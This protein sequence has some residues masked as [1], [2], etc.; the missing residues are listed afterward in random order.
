MKVI[1]VVGA[2][3]NFMKVA[4]LHRAIQQLSGWTSKIVH[5]GQHF[6]AKMSD[7]FFTQLELP[8]PDYFLGIGGGSHTEVTA[9][10]MLAFEK[11]V[12]DEKPD[13]II[14]VGDVTSTLACTLV[15]IKMGIHVAHVEAGLRSF[16]R[17]MPEELNR[18]L[19]DSVANYLFVTEESGLNHL[20]NEGV[21]DEKV[22][23]SGNVM[24]DSLV[25]YQE[26]AKNSTILTDLGLRPSDSGQSSSE[27]GLI[28]SNYIVMTMH[29]PAN[30]DTEKGL[31]SILELMELSAQ[32]TKIVFPIHPRTRAHMD[33]FGLT[34]RMEALPNL[35][36]TEP[37]GYLEFI[38]LMSHA[39]AILTDS[40]GIQEETTYLGIP[41]L[42]FRD[43]TERP[44]TV[45]LGTNQLLADLD[46][47]KTYQALE[48]I[49]AG[50]VKK[51]SI[52][53]LW[54]GHAAERIANTLHGIFEKK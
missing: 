15:A 9:H 12:A 22:F 50:E 2:R 43:S 54:D 11:I 44:V 24:I 33:K 4:P 26:K 36:L 46:P 53:P 1:Q 5:T 45:T 23:F 34:K 7:V 6:D 3:P 32:K 30:V 28:P 21:P 47:Q 49:L 38:Q 25:R 41:C 31:L 17:T 27:F 10:I 19:T 16:D 52:P 20:K 8:K 29:R 39:N 14:V 13:L 51:G 35:I 40:G 18:L 48:K 37:L 42:T